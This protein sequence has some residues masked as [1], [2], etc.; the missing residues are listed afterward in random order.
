MKTI[1]ENVIK[2]GGYDLT[3]M[4]AK[5]DA[6]HIE[7]KLTDAER[8]ELYTLART[9]PEAQYDY[10]G[11]IERLWAAVRELQNGDISSEGNGDVGK[12]KIYPWKQPTGAHNAYAF[13]AMM[14]YT[15]GDVY[16]S[17]LDNNVWSPDVHPAGW[18]KLDGIP[19][20]W[21]LVEEG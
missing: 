12:R 2:K 14:L 11:E 9:A 6:Y 21:K 5:I 3:T 10:K 15:D 1:F 4:I 17:L 7:G 13:D 20:G 16:Q 8:D 19:D 18:K